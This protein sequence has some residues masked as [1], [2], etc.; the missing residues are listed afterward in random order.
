MSD[1][2]DLMAMLGILNKTNLKKYK[3]LFVAH[4]FVVNADPDLNGDDS[5]FPLIWL[6]S[7]WQVSV[8]VGHPCSI[9]YH[10]DPT[11][12]KSLLC[13]R[14]SLHCL[15]ISTLDTIHC[16]ICISTSGFQ[17]PLA[18]YA[19]CFNSRGVWYQFERLYV[20]MIMSFSPKEDLNME[21]AG[22]R[23]I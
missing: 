10:G 11:W 5:V 14:P 20:W 15:G 1:E 7:S 23:L 8:G 12:L 16:N 18:N 9:G 3:W 13:F 22:H 6:D 4:D 19:G 2:V 21:K 17:A